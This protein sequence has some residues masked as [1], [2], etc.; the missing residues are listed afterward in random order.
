MFDVTA[1]DDSGTHSAAASV[2]IAISTVGSEEIDTVPTTFTLH[3]NYP[4]PFNPSTTIQYELSTTGAVQLS[5][6]DALGRQVRRLI[7]QEQ[8]PGR[9]SVVWNGKNESGTLLSSAMYFVR[10]QT[11]GFVQTRK[12]ILLK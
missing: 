12:I 4:N 1:S 5:V 11:A 6:F 9:Y 8:S 2:T 10:L 3:Q 7:S